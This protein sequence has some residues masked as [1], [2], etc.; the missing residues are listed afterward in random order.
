MKLFRLVISLFL[1]FAASSSFAAVV[2]YTEAADKVRFEQYTS[3]DA[4]LVLWRLPYPGTSTF[5]LANGTAGP[6]PAIGLPATNTTLGNRFLS[7]YMFVK[8][9]ASTYFVQY[10]TATC[11]IISF[12]MDG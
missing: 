4:P 8:T 12:G 2:L 9:N 6:C 5:P 1:F 7:L 10:D 3:G 11:N